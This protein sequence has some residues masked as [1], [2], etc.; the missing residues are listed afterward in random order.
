MLCILFVNDTV[1]QSTCHNG[2]CQNCIRNNSCINGT[3]CTSP[4]ECTTSM[5][6][7][8]QCIQC[9]HGC[10]NGDSC[11]KKQACLRNVCELGKCARCV[12]KQ[13]VTGNTC[14]K[15]ADCVKSL[16]ECKR[17]KL[18]PILTLFYFQREIMINNNV[19]RV[20]GI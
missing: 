7:N 17:S 12:E 8:K 14:S 15:S 20:I 6:I 19:N 18:V 3:E 1:S 9:S 13:C 16:I 5:C 10:S 2:Q 4:H 11:A